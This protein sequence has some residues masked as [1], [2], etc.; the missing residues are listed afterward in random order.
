MDKIEL[1]RTKYL[2]EIDKEKDLQRASK[3]HIEELKESLCELSPI[4][5]GDKVDYK[6]IMGWICKFG[7]SEATGKPIDFYVNPEK[8]DG[9]RSE[10]V[11]YLT[12]NMDDI[13]V[14]QKS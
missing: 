11:K 10:R 14:L 4:K 5:I 8:K 6:G 13:V 9:T 1:L 7:I 3:R 2:Q 12:W